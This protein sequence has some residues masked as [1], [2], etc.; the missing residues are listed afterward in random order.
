VTG[1]SG[2]PVVG[3]ETHTFRNGG[4]WIVALMTNPQ[5]RVDELGPPEFKSND[6][7]AK[8]IAVKLALPGQRFVYDV[9]AAKA[10]GRLGGVQLTLDPYEPTILAIAE[11]PVPELEV[12]AP[13]RVK[14]GDTGTL[15][16]TFARATAAA[17]HVLHIDVVNPSGEIVRYYSGN[18]LA[19]EGRAARLIPI[20]ISDPV[21]RW[22]VRVKDLLSAQTKTSSFEVF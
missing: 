10:M 19:P 11:S 14:R 17:N 12:S 2:Q 22:E 6:R 8:P 9:R 4:V 3:V 16:V 18:V 7:F 5:L 13:G 1:A 21:G 15:G 20:A